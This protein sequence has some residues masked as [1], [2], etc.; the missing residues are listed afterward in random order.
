MHV[1]TALRADVIQGTL[2]GAR[3]KRLN[4]SPAAVYV[5]DHATPTQLAHLL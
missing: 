5:S 3:V 2:D 1:D 4:K